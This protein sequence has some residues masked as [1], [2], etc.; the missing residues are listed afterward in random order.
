[1]VKKIVKTKNTKK[2]KILKIVK[3]NNK[4]SK[5]IIKFSLLLGNLVQNSANPEPSQFSSSSYEYQIS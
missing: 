2:N 3:K 5:S 4:N 1:M